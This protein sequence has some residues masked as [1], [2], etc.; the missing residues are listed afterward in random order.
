MKVDAERPRELFATFGNFEDSGDTRPRGLH[1]Q[2]IG[3]RGDT[4]VCNP[5]EAERNK[6]FFKRRLSEKRL[7]PVI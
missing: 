4:G 7:F 5:P 6:D 3:A 2:R 1:R